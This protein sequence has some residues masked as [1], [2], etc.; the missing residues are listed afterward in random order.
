MGEKKSLIPCFAFHASRTQ[1]CPS[2]VTL[3]NLIILICVSPVFVA[4]A[5]QSNGTGEDANRHLGSAYLAYNGIHEEFNRGRCRNCHPAIWRE[6]EKSRHA[7]AWKD[8]IYQETAGR[9]PNR[10]E[11]CDPCHA[12]QPILIT[13]I[14]KM[15]KLRETHRGSGVSCLVC[16]VDAKG[17]MHGPPAS[18]DAVVH[19]NITDEAHQNP[20]ELCGTCHGQPSVP[21][22]N[23]LASFKHSPA[24]TA[25]KH[26]A[27]CHMPAIKRLQSLRS[28][29]PIPGGRHTWIAS[30]SVDMLK[31]AADLTITFAK[32]KAMIHITNK[33]GHVLPGGWTRKLL[34]DVKIYDSGGSVVGHEQISISGTSGE[35]GSDNRL[36]PGATR[37]FTYEFG[38]QAQI[39]AKLRYRLRPTTPE[40]EWITM[41]EARQIVQ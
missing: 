10:E 15:P 14:E 9:I 4:N 7:Q 36:Q 26:C 16:H 20:T 17:G 32:S 25:G 28:N 29:E 23:Q 40:T 30:R 12:P 6:W 1:H 11:S 8:P 34:L 24:A 21:E 35:G 39:E 19:A 22:Y 18:I 5:E 37:Q 31:S 33:S 13:G 27:T 3:I 41:G 2:S 38:S